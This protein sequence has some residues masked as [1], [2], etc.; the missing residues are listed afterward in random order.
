M[1]L[2]IEYLVRKGL[3]RQWMKVPCS[4]FTIEQGTFNKV[5]ITINEE[6]KP[7]QFYC[8]KHWHVSACS[9]SQMLPS[10]SEFRVPKS[11]VFSHES[12]VV[13]NHRLLAYHASPVPFSE[14]LSHHPMDGKIYNHYYDNYLDTMNH[15]EEK[16]NWLWKEFVQKYVP[17]LCDSKAYIPVY[18]SS[19]EIATDQRSMVASLYSEIWQWWIKWCKYMLCID[20]FPGELVF[21]GEYRRQG[22]LWLDSKRQLGSPSALFMS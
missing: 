10:F 18:K 8:V 14:N 22:G 7:S 9:R 19:S 21:L 17:Q 12:V 4:L 16:L 6:F 5:A 20:C 3:I 15:K 11:D 1:H 2:A 13:P